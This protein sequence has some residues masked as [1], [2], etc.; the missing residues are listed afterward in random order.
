MDGFDRSL[1]V[2][3]ALNRYENGI[4]KL[5]SPRADAEALA[6][7]L[8]QQHGFSIEQ[9]KDDEATKPRLRA[10]LGELKWRLGPRDR[11][12]FYFAGHGIAFPSDDG[13]KGFILLHDA[14]KDDLIPGES[15]F[16]MEELEE[17]LSELPC[18]HMLVV[19]D[20]CFAGA[21]RWSSTRSVVV[22]PGRLHR[23]RYDWFIADPAWQVIASAAHNQEA[24]DIV[25]RQPLGQ[26]EDE[27][28]NSPFARALLEG[29]KGAADQ[30][31]SEIAGDGVI[32]ATELYLYIDTALRIALQH[33]HQQQMPLL[34][35]MR[36]HERGQFVFL[37]PGRSPEELPPAPELTED[38]NPWRG[39][40]SYDV[41]NAE[42]FFGRRRVSEAL[43]NRLTGIAPADVGPAQPAQRF[44]VVTGPSGIGKSSLVKAGLLSR[45]PSDI[46]AAVTQPGSGPFAS[47]ATALR[48]AAW[49]SGAPPDAAILSSD[50]GALAAWIRAQ[51][52]RKIVL[53]VDQL[54][55]LL[56]MSPRP[57]ADPAPVAQL[58][59][60]KWV[61][62]MLP[63]S[64]LT[65]SVAQLSPT[66]KKARAASFGRLGRIRPFRQ[67]FSRVSNFLVRS[68][69]GKRTSPDVAD[70]YLQLLA[71]ALRDCPNLSIVLTV[72]AEYEP[73][74]VSRPLG[75]RW[76]EAKV[77]VPQ[78]SHEELRRVVE[79]P[80]SIRVMRFDP[81]AM[82]ERLADEVAQ[83]PGALPLLS[84]ALSEM[85]RNAISRRDTDRTLTLADYAVLR[86]GVIGSLRTRANALLAELD[87]AHRLTAQR[88]LLRLVSIEGGEYARRRVPLAE[89]EASSPEEQRRIDCVLH[90]LD[91]ARLIVR[92]ILD[93]VPHLEL[94][95]DSLIMSWDTLF[96]W[97]RDD[98]ALL[99][100]HRQLAS[101]ASAWSLKRGWLSSRLWS[102]GRRIAILRR[103]LA[104]PTVSLNRVER[105]FARA[106]LLRHWV[107]RSMLIAAGLSVVAAV[108]ISQNAF[109]EMSQSR[110]MNAIQELGE[111]NVA[112]ALDSAI[113]AV[114]MQP[115]LR[116]D[117][118]SSTL[119]EAAAISTLLALSSRRPAEISKEH[120]AA[121]VFSRDGTLLATA[122]SDAGIVVRSTRTGEVLKRHPTQSNPSDIMFAGASRTI[123]IA[124]YD[125]LLQTWN[126]D[127]DS[128]QPFASAN[129]NYQS[130]AILPD[131]TQLAAITQA[132]AGPLL[133]VWDLTSMHRIASAPIQ[134]A[135]NV[136]GF[137]TAERIAI[138]EDRGFRIVETQTL[139][140]VCSAPTDL[141]DLQQVM[142]MSD[143][144]S[145]A[146][147]AKASGSPVFAVFDNTCKQTASRPLSQGVITNGIL[148]SLGRSSISAALRP[149]GIHVA[150]IVIDEDELQRRR[151]LRIDNQQLNPFIYREL[152]IL[153][154]D[155]ILT[156][157]LLT[158]HAL[159]GRLSLPRR[160]GGFFFLS[161][162]PGGDFIDAAKSSCASTAADT[163]LASPSKFVVDID[164]VEKL[165]IEGKLTADGALT[166][167]Q[168][169]HLTR[170]PISLSTPQYAKLHI[171]R[172]GRNAYVT[173]PKALHT[174]NL[175][176]GS[177][178]QEPLAEAIS[179]LDADA[180]SGW[181]VTV[182]AGGSLRLI[183]P[184]PRPV[185][186]F[187]HRS[188]RSGGHVLQSVIS[189]A[190]LTEGGHKTIYA[191]HDGTLNELDNESLTARKISV[192][193]LDTSSDDIDRRLFLLQLDS[194]GRFVLTASQRT[195][196]IVDLKTERQT[197]V[198]QFPE[199]RGVTAALFAASGPLAF[200]SAG[201]KTSVIDWSLCRTLGAL[202]P[203]EVQKLLPDPMHRGVAYL[204]R[205]AFVH[206]DFLIRLDRRNSIH[207]LLAALRSVRQPVTLTPVQP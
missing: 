29:L 89:F 180:S 153:N 202:I 175:R 55:E 83:M 37:V 146:I 67:I 125:G 49:A 205:G 135:Y 62:R 96:R 40:S 189:D 35:P 36:K 97:I 141:T 5:S 158:D 122:S 48:S 42:L 114:E 190:R 84:F 170:I 33:S 118:G 26:R 1:A 45:L 76:H 143:R 166:I 50:S 54:E 129:G 59:N 34:W 120:V 77:F 107:T 28:R 200:V 81:P 164:I 187:M 8:A 94:A 207:D 44:I 88:V 150:E 61:D 6:Q 181:L 15:F 14:R 27:R 169:S 191:A 174:V 92:D 31:T 152:N 139:R 183:G 179:V 133:E 7:V 39:L 172:A 17:L 199:S 47:L 12:F 121:A 142:L 157:K 127:D 136:A 87:E 112:G 71:E 25:A 159:T 56:T 30:L 85:Y 155:D 13:Q 23:E 192:P 147:L 93:G 167:A 149:D 177:I 154:V 106:S 69:V 80:A 24:I 108:P 53:V 184:S 65:V 176:S 60:W 58:T 72:R 137:V 161:S 117:F 203:F 165:G 134:N 82:V 70:F 138:A 78:M 195:V 204:Q 104:H 95:H 90:R 193:A 2:L 19:L 116:L 110:A 148:P 51:G 160:G 198:L 132:D 46:S 99:P 168:N 162:Q 74:F 145:I 126:M 9:L 91:N 21:F 4:Q 79:G 75:D 201:G 10:L 52:G 151:V 123:V 156:C 124:G 20:C 11:V 22:P 115:T 171:D 98:A 57:R 43:L 185:R 102:G 197:C 68:R 101:D 111:R 32:T 119:A 173:E 86:G 144:A 38:A 196:V 66:I 194:T 63:T 3:I 186:T 100:D 109:D 105:V 188:K 103:L 130:I 140:M 18:R 41:G 64:A 73:Q 178:A 113:S 16:P 182:Q 206:G 128:V 131:G 163:L